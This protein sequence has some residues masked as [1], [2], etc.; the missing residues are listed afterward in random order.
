MVSLA[1]YRL[2]Y[3]QTCLRML[4]IIIINQDVRLISQ[5]A[6]S[7][8]LS[9]LQCTPLVMLSRT[10]MAKGVMPLVLGF[11]PSWVVRKLYLHKRYLFSGRTTIE[12]YT[13]LL[14]LGIFSCRGP[15]QPARIDTRA[16]NAYHLGVARERTCRSQW[17]WIRRPW[18]W[19]DALNGAYRRI[20]PKSVLLLTGALWLEWNW[21]Y[22]EW[23]SNF[24]TPFARV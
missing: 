5:I 14:W 18:Y 2:H 22:S 8:T 21:H 6:C 13:L 20:Y 12:L 9:Y 24:H 16:S 1:L 10:S 7:R 4:F 19:F 23:W 11:V 17:L 15:A 3:K